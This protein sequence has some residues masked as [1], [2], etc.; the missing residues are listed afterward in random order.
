MSARGAAWLAWALYALCVALATASLI[1]GLVNRRILGEIFMAS[2]PFNSR[3][4]HPDRVVLRRRGFDR[5]APSREP[6]RLDLLDRWL[7]LWARRRSPLR[8]TRRCT[9]FR[10]RPLSIET[11]ASPPSQR[12]SRR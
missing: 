3:P 5:L 8:E 4:R 1:L 10:R 7:L 12:Y 6:H 2:S 9:T 11:R